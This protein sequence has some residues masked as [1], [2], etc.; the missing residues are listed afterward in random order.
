MMKI[1]QYAF[2]KQIQ[3][4]QDELL[5]L[6][7]KRYKFRDIVKSNYELGQ[8]HYERENFSDAVL[9]FKLVVWLDPNRADGW[10]SLGLS[11]IAVGKKTDAIKALNKALRLKPDWV[12]ARD[13]LA[14][15]SET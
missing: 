14:K 8:L 2:S 1:S 9:R 3:K 13:A 4:W 10:Y 11:Q 5:I 12:Q 15:A 7:G 6:W